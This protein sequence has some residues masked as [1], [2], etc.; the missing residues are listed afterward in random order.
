MVP[1]IYYDNPGTY[2]VTFIA[3][4]PGTCNG[5]DT[6]T[7]VITAMKGPLA[8]FTFTP[9]TPE[10]NI[11]ITYL[12]QSVDATRYSWA[13]G[14]GTGSTEVNPVHQ[15]N[16]TGIYKTCLTAYNE[17]N[18]PSIV[19][20]NVETEIV[21]IVDIPTGF[22]PNG[23]G[24]NDIL[25]VRGAAIKT[26]DL[27]IYNRWGQMIFQTKSQSEG[28]DGTYSGEQQ[29]IDAYGYVL[30]VTFIDGSK[31]TLKGNITLLR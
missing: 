23:D 31:K 19:C 27:K 4:N 11:P 6:F 13:F 26:L 14:D 12:N 10:T 17:S 29:P 1:S 2:T 20:K 15:F 5:A 30:L 25:F 9:A 18:C 21:P 22:S 3:I 24:Q 8:A 7:R 28:W 16:K